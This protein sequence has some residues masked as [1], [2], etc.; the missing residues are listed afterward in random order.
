VADL[1][2]ENHKAGISHVDR[3]IGEPMRGPSLRS[4]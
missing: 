1:Y 4:G 3:V 2:R